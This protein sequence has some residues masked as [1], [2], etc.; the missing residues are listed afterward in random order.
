VEGAPEYLVIGNVTKDLLPDGDYSLGGTATYSA[1]TAVRLGARTAVL[2][3]CEVE[4]PL[5]EHEPGIVVACIPSATT[6]TFENLY[7]GWA[8]QQY[9]RAE[10]ATLLPDHIP[11]HW[12][13]AEIV[14]LGP[15]AHECHPSLAGAFGGQMLG[16]TP[17]GWLRQWNG[18]GL[19]QPD[20]YACD[21]ELVRA[22]DVGVLSLEDL[23]DD[24]KALAH[25]VRLARLLV[26]TLGPEGAIM[27]E[28]GRETRAP[29]FQVEQADPTGAG[30]VF[31]TAFL[32]RYHETG[33]ALA[34]AM[35]ANC[36]A[37]FIIESVGTA[38]VPTRE[39]VQERLTH[40]KLRS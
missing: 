34:A 11:A 32:L 13:Q 40:G 2:T 8:R 25:Y 17:Q 1:L 30:D 22:A 39:R 26:L 15:I 7:S 28:R 21:P 5:F 6:T 33:D 24:R 16:I 12:R 31:A 20:P 9:I 35:Y 23:G 38:N 27:F 18:Q 4:L 3:S 29:A 10:A 19:V 37:S 36:V 14:H